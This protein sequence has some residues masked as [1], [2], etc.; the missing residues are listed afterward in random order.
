L[1]SDAIRNGEKHKETFDM[2]NHWILDK[3]VLHKLFKVLVPR[4]QNYDSSFTRIV[5]APTPYPAQT[6][7]VLRSYSARAIIELKGN[8]YPAIFPAD[9]MHRNKNYIHNVLLTAA[10]REQYK[11]NHKSSSQESEVD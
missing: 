11:D 2:A 6:D 3:S 10:R 8:P 7:K 9:K 4:F 5:R 1:I